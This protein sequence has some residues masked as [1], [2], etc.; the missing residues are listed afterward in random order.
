MVIGSYAIFITVVVAAV[1]VAVT[2]SGGNPRHSNNL[3]MMI[4]LRSDYLSVIG[5]L[6]SKL[7]LKPTINYSPNLSVCLN[8]TTAERQLQETEY[9]FQVL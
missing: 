2:T 9:V 4:F 5:S 1:G 3:V 6:D 7:L 8:E